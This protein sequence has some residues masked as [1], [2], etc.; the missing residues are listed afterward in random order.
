MSEGFG[1]EIDSKDSMG[2]IGSLEVGDKTV[3]TPALMP[4][5]N[6]HLTRP[7]LSE[8]QILI[9]NAYIINKSDD[10][11]EKAVEDGLHDSLDF[12]GV[13]VTDSGSY[14]MSVYGEDEVTLSNRETVEF[15]VEIGTDVATPLDIPTPPDSSHETAEDDWETTL[16]RIKEAREILSELDAEAG[17]NVPVQGSTHPDLRER[18]GREASGLGDVYPVGAVVPLMQEYRFGD[19]VDV[20]AAAKRGLDSDAP[21]HLFGAGHPMIFSLAVA[22]GCDLFD[23]AAYALYAEDGRYIT[24]EGTKYVDDLRELPCSCEVCVSH[25]ADDLRDSHDLLAQHNLNVS[26]AE[27]RRVRQAVREGNL[28]ELVEQRCRSHPKLLDGLRNFGDHADQIEKYD[29]ASKSTV[30]SLGLG[31]RP[32]VVRHHRRLDRIGVDDGD[33]VLVVP[34]ADY[35]EDG[36]EDELDVYTDDFDTVLRL[37]PPLGPFPE[38][39]SHSY[40]FNAEVPEEPSHDEVEAVYEGVLRLVRLYDTDAVLVS[41]WDHPLLGEIENEDVDVIRR[42]N[43]SKTRNSNTETEQQT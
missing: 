3:Q 25:D 24:P 6:P 30:F 14:Q 41:P 13:V 43:G 18:A 39:L 38:S 22:V 29:P 27:M 19:L 4:V 16:S 15:Q 37:L 21:V 9:T 31:R 42:S 36:W 28:I 34:T 11:R 17:L 20:V 23:S 12:D 7:D 32:E 33:R 1:F 35:L 26:F 2:R 8:A 10:Y 5:I 40:P